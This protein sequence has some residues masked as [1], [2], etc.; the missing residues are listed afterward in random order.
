MAL[1]R[2]GRTMIGSKRSISLSGAGPPAGWPPGISPL[3]EGAA[4]VPL[5]WR[6][7][8]LRPVE[9]HHRQ[10]QRESGAKACEED[11]GDDT[12][13]MRRRAGQ[14]NAELH[15]PE[16]EYSREPR[17]VHGNESA[18]RPPLR[19]LSERPPHQAEFPVRPKLPAETR[20][21]ALEIPAPDPGQ[22]IQV[23]NG[24]QCAHDRGR[25]VTSRHA[26]Y[27]L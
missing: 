8:E 15:R 27:H 10:K 20:L 26:S 22:K 21:P 2:P 13:R 18:D 4:I 3:G 11:Q 7:D 5:R 19:H 14:M 25:D 16:T 9:E 23:P 12:P 24:Y 17:K 1:R 6:H